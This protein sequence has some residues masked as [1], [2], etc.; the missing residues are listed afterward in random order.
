ML[1]PTVNMENVE[2]KGSYLVVKADDGGSYVMSPKGDWFQ[3]SDSGCTCPEYA[4]FGACPHTRLVNGEQEV[5]Q[6]SAEAAEPRTRATRTRSE[7]PRP[8]ARAQNTQDSTQAAATIMLTVIE[9]IEAMATAYVEACQA[10][11]QG[12][13]DAEPQAADRP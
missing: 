4:R 3:V 1:P 13:R 9:L 8:R 10:Q 5:I 2:Q 7:A 12:A 6:P 11:R